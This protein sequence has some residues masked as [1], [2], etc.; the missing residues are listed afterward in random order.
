MKKLFIAF[1]FL[2]LLAGCGAASPDETE[3]TIPDGTHMEGQKDYDRF[4]AT[5]LVD[6]KTGKRY[7]VVDYS[8]SVDIEPLQ[9]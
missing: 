5:I 3:A 4:V 2:V 6:E 1:L 8:D 7:I 9:E